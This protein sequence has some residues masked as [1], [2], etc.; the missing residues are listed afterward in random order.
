M[1]LLSPRRGK[2]ISIRG[3][4]PGKLCTRMF[5]QEVKLRRQGRS[6]M[7]FVNDQRVKK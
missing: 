3:L 7:I 2:E 6:A 5:W 4:S 1:Y